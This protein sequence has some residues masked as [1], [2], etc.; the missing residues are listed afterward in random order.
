MADIDAKIAA[1]TATKSTLTNLIGFYQAQLKKAQQQLLQTDTSINSLKQQRQTLGNAKP[2][3]TNAA[4][5]KEL[6]TEDGKTYYYNK[7][8][9]E[10]TWTNPFTKD[11]KPEQNLQE[12]WREA[13]T[14]D[15]RTYYYN[16]QTKETTWVNPFGGAG[17][18][19]STSSGAPP[20]A[21]SG[22]SAPK[23]AP[24]KALS[25]EEK[26][27]DLQDKIK[28]I[29]EQIQAKMKTRDGLQKLCG[30]YGADNPAVVKA[31]AEL[32][33]LE[34]ELKGLKDKKAGWV[35][36]LEELCPEL[37]QQATAAKPAA[38]A[39]A[40]KEFQDA[41]GRTY[42]YNMT[43]KETR[44]EKPDDAAPAPATGAVAKVTFFFFFRIFL[45]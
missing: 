15:G 10:T 36:E 3:S 24:A 7:I 25:P 23:A 41:S 43:T 29:K 18:K 26:K 32:D 9:K 8:T 44:W 16:K 35:K 4:D 19:P 21:P 13:K 38:Q 2:T 12:I 30:F 5:W 31:K 42:Y 34:K 27:K 11:A 6:K 22:S 45:L 37:K 17:A 39:S 14:E 40:W 1:G 28:G 20:A 33:G